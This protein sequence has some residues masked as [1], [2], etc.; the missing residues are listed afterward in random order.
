MME[1]TKKE[2]KRKERGRTC[3]RIEKKEIGSE[4]K[5][6]RNGRETDDKKRSEEGRGKAKQRNVIER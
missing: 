4:Q 6:N 5:P 2:C 3:E 1:V